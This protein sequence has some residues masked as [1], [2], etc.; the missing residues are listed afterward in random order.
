MEEFVS[1]LVEQEKENEN[2]YQKNLK[3]QDSLQNIFPDIYT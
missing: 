1:G 3:R 2:R